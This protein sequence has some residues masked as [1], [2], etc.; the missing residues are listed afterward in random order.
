MN[1]IRLLESNIPP[2]LRGL[3]LSSPVIGEMVLNPVGV[4]ESYA[5][6]VR[7]GK[8]VQA[9][10][11][12]G[13]CGKGIWAQGDGSTALLAALLQDLMDTD[14]FGATVMYLNADNYLES[15]RPDGERSQAE[16][17]ESDHL[18]LLSHLPQI[19][20]LTDWGRATI[21]SLLT[22]RFDAGLPTFVASNAKPDDYLSP[23]LAVEAFHMV[24][25]IRSEP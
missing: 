13:T 14:D 2:R 9:E 10:G 3:R 21:G 25:I 17:A 4:I 15:M 20:Y 19:R 7:A 5:A 6:S 24:A 16:R 11:Q 23:G 1:K 8:V 22:R 12:Y 18:L